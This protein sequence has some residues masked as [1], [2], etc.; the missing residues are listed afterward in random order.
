MFTIP[1]II[2]WPRNEKKQRNEWNSIFRIP[3]NWHSGHH[4]IDIYEN[5]SSFNF[6]EQK[7]KFSNF[8]LSI[9]QYIYTNRTKTRFIYIRIGKT[10]KRK[11]N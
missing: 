4:Q 10:K 5:I 9:V 7:E 8:N 6:T 2:T 3:Y 11:E 1:W